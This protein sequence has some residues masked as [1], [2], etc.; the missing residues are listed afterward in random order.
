MVDGFLAR[1]N[2]N[3]VLAFFLIN[4][5]DKLI[6][7]VAVWAAVRKHPIRFYHFSMVR[8]R[9]DQTENFDMNR[10]YRRVMTS[11]AVEAIG[12]VAV[13]AWISVS[14]YSQNARRE[15]IM[16]AWGA[17]QQVVNAVDPRL[18]EVYLNRGTSAQSYEEVRNVLQGIRDNY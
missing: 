5:A 17:A 16:V 4:I 11:A 7:T 10:Q 18:I 6:A 12:L 9:S 15:R 1:A 3:R 8:G 13:C 14:L 2:D